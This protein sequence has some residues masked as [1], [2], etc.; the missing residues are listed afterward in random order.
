MTDHTL[1]TVLDGL[2]FGEGPRWHDGRLWFSDMHA[3]HVIATTPD[4]DAE[5]IC[6][7][8]QQPS[9]LGWDLQ[10]R[11]LVV[12][13]IDRR[14]LR[15]EADGT[16]SEV[17][18]LFELAPFHCNDMVVSATGHAYVGN[19]GFDYGLPGVEPNNT[20]VVRVAPDGTA[21]EAAGDLGFPNGMVITPDG[22][23]LI[24]GESFGFRLTAFDIAPDGTLFNRRLWAQLD[25]ATPDGICLDAEGAIWLACPMSHRVV[26]V[27]GGGRIL[28]EVS[29]GDRNAYACML[30][31]DDRRTLF[32]C[33]AESSNP[34]KTLPKMTGRIENTRVDVPGAGLP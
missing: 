21:S 12:S 25:G 29:V 5:T 16:L 10:G 27:A 14:L 26:R 6:E 3:K 17:A 9:G 33:T 7:V 31:G 11:L 28:D 8:A 1:T 2:A 30:G 24:V 34:A 13:M 23:T 20:N 19:F 22:G 15:L 32:V 18:N 4:G